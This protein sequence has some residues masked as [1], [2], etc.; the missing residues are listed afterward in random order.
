[1]QTC[2]SSKLKQYLDGNG[3]SRET[4]AWEGTLLV[5][6]TSTTSTDI[7]LDISFDILIFHFSGNDNTTDTNN[8]RSQNPTL[9]DQIPSWYSWHSLFWS[10]FKL[11]L[12]PYPLVGRIKLK[13]KFVGCQVLGFHIPTD[14]APQF[15]RKVAWHK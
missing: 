4:K 5:T 7:S 10:I 14:P 13:V 11:Q 6:C 1:M 2:K 15:L 12:Q 8:N 9:S 3:S